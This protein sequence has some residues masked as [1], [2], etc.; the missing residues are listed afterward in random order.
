MLVF[1]MFLGGARS[2]LTK[3]LNKSEKSFYDALKTNAY[4]FVFAFI[5]VLVLGIS[6]LG[7]IFQVPWWLALVYAVSMVLAQVCLMKAVELGPVSTSSFI[8]YCGFIVALL[9]GS[10]YYKETVNALHIIGILLIIVSFVCSVK[11]EEKKM[12]ALW[13]VASFGGF[14]F[15]GAMGIWQ[16]IFRYEY[17]E[18]N[19]DNF[20][21][22]AFLLMIIFSFL[23]TILA[24]LTKTKENSVDEGLERTAVSNRKKIGL[25]ATLGV[26]MGLINIIN[27]F[28]AGALPSVIVFPCIYGGGIIATSILSLLILKEKITKKQ[29]Y[30]LWIGILGIVFIGVGATL[31]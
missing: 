10:I 16:K 7:T 12:S 13:A 3:T 29:W 25:I 22:V 30:S 11:K 17:T 19:L 9:F 6:S 20:M 23:L 2:I 14:L 26:S 21:Q 1:T 27:T 15:G 4:V 31:V 5:I 24:R 8:Y 18:H 28:L